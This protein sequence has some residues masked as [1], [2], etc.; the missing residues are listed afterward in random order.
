MA[1]SHII[2]WLT[3][4]TQDLLQRRGAAAHISFAQELAGLSGL[5]CHLSHLRGGCGLSFL[6]IH[7]LGDLDWI[8]ALRLHA[9]IAG[10]ATDELIHIRDV[11]DLGPD[12]ND[13]AD[14]LQQA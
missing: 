14:K 11:L 4:S 9:N 10:V 8:E 2:H 13:V 6:L 1:R 3:L 7:L 5:W 12:R